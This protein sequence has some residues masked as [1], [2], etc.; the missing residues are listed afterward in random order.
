LVTTTDGRLV[1]SVEA[2]FT[3]SRT[4]IDLSDLPTGMYILAGVTG[5]EGKIG[6]SQQ[7]FKY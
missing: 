6:F 2:V 1:R 7:V 5:K 3:N 4:V